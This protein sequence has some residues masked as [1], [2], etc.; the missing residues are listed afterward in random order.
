MVAEGFAAH[1]K[2]FIPL[3]VTER[4]TRISCIIYRTD[5]TNFGY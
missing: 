1:P 4:F 5:A 2:A 3:I